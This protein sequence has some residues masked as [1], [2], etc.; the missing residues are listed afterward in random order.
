[1]DPQ[2]AMKQDEKDRLLYQAIDPPTGPNGATL[3]YIYTETAMSRFYKCYL[4]ENALLRRF[5]SYSVQ[6]RLMRH[7]QKNMH[8]FRWLKEGQNAIQVGCTE[9][10]LD[11]GVSQAMIMSALAGPRGKLLAIDPDVRNLDCLDRYVA[12]HNIQNVVHVQ[13]AAWRERCKAN[14][15]FY[16]DRTSSNVITE[17]EEG[18]VWEIE[19]EG[20]PRESREIELN[21]ID[22]IV[23]EIGYDPHFVNIS[24]NDAE[25]GAI[26]GM[27]RIL[28]RRKTTISW[29]IG[30][31]RPWWVES[32]N[33]C[34]DRG[35]DVIMGNAPYSHRGPA[36]SGKVRLYDYTEVPQEFYAVAVPVERHERHSNEVPAR[37]EVRQG[38]LDFVVTPLP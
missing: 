30:G 21:T 22:N 10:M 14:F 27:E 26:Q 12:R 13:A 29:L 31:G 35:Y 19:H 11:F 23:E 8:P 37:L 34:I 16:A 17:I 36:R 24:I 25:F 18:A 5:P 7:F 38:S 1:M 4:R 6:Y 28:E 9:W 32:I 20:R 3:T 15:S 2:L 33:F